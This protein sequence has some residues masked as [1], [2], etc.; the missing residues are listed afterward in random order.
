MSKLTDLHNLYQKLRLWS[1]EIPFDIDANT[2][3]GEALDAISDALG[4]IQTAMEWLP[5]EETDDIQLKFEFIKQYTNAT[6]TL[7]FMISQIE[8]IT[9]KILK[10]KKNDSII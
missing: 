8:E 7:P 1:E 3:L 10:D 5:I 6:I 4:N 2:P 9:T